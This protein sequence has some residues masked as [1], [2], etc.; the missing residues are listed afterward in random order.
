[1][2]AQ[3]IV[4]S[5]SSP[6][7]F[8][9]NATAMFPIRC[10]SPSFSSSSFLNFGDDFIQIQFSPGLVSCTFSKK[11]IIP[12][13]SWFSQAALRRNSQVPKMDCIPFSETEHFSLQIFLRQNS[14]HV[15]ELERQQPSPSVPAQPVN[16]VRLSDQIRHYIHMPQSA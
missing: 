10:I 13:W 6:F 8:L 11:T 15:L 4:F 1:M 7:S 9:N 3:Q 14:A 2:L 5:S 12:F 16:L